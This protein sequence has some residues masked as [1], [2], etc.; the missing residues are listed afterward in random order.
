MT[1]V[2]I[3]EGVLAYSSEMV[4]GW[5]WD[6]GVGH[7]NTYFQRYFPISNHLPHFQ[8]T[9]LDFGSENLMDVSVDMLLFIIKSD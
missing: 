7:N 9:Y 6:I 5:L 8:T 1:V 4:M 3:E 2:W